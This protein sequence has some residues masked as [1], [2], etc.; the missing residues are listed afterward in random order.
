[1]RAVTFSMVQSDGRAAV[2]SRDIPTP[3][4]E[5][6]WYVLPWDFLL[7]HCDNIC[8][9]SPLQES[10]GEWLMSRIIISVT[11]L[12][13]F[14]S[15]PWVLLWKS[16]AYIARHS[17]LIM[18]VQGLTRKGRAC[19]WHH[20]APWTAVRMSQ[21]NVGRLKVAVFLMSGN[22]IL[23]HRGSFQCSH[24]QSMSNYFDRKL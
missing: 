19:R 4:C 7:I 3:N 1:M 10:H 20:A 14:L 22:K 6:V 13:T 24:R 18:K 21:V 11:S 12:L 17:L 15:S 23:L 2:W 9:F 16:D 5:H 8:F